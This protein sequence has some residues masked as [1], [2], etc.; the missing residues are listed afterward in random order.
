MIHTAIFGNLGSRGTTLLKTYGGLQSLVYG[1]GCQL[2]LNMDDSVLFD[3]I[4]RTLT[5]LLPDKHQYEADYQLYL[6]NS[7]PLHPDIP[8]LE[9]IPGEESHDAI[10]EDGVLGEELVVTNEKAANAECQQAAGKLLEAD[11][12]RFSVTFPQLRNAPHLTPREAE[13]I[14]DEEEAY[15][16]NPII[17]SPVNNGGYL[18][19]YEPELSMPL[20]RPTAADAAAEAEPLPQPRLL[21]GNHSNGVE[22][23]SISGNQQEP[24][25]ATDMPV[26]TNEEDTAEPTQG[27]CQSADT[28]VQSIIFS[29][30]KSE[31][32][33]LRTYN[34][35]RPALSRG[36][37]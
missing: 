31:P 18:A 1:H 30:Q 35:S 3:T 28:E 34:L 10:S 19:S 15:G 27:A 13:V 6:D 17:E 22:V 26:I 25:M 7:L 20:L 2:A 16:E 33:Q 11:T 21:G 5:D 37:A 4:D 36:A 32:A 14:A 24:Q 12:E 8:T 23:D 9:D 29:E